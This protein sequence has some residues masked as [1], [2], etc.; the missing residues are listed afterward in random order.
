MGTV[1]V[2]VS[3]AGPGIPEEDL[4]RVFERFYRVDEARS[5][6]QG[7]AGLGLSLALVTLFSLRSAIPNSSDLFQ[8]VQS[9]DLLLCIVIIG[10]LF[11]LAP[12]FDGAGR[13]RLGVLAL[14]WLPYAVGGWS[15]WLCQGTGVCLVR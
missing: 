13:R 1:A 11:E 10:R 12:S 5:R 8:F 4:S 6:D 14:V 3:D 2:A 15:L 7:G 9:A